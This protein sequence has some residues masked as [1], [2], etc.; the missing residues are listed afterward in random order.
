MPDESQSF[1][2]RFRTEGEAPQL[3]LVPNIVAISGNERDESDTLELNDLKQTA[4]SSDTSILK[5]EDISTSLPGESQSGLG[6]SQVSVQVGEVKTAHV[7][8]PSKTV[9][10]TKGGQM[11]PQKTNNETPVTLSSN[12]LQHDSTDSGYN[13][14]MS[15]SGHYSQETLELNG[16]FLAK[17]CSI[18]N[19]NLYESSFDKPNNIS[20]NSLDD[21]VGSAALRAD[22]TRDSVDIGSSA[23]SKDKDDDGHSMRSRRSVKEGMCCCYRTTSRAFLQCVEETPAML[24]GLLLSLIFCVVIIVLVPATGRVRQTSLFVY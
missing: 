3:S 15:I 14:T 11:T 4:H 7:P 22:Q 13:S 18:S 2:D 12:K 24:T 5:R 23:G 21:G 17:T 8:E 19:S 9:F 6:A 1:Q 10:F 20:K 16:K